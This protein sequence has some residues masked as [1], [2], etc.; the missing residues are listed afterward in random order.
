M[1]KLCSHFVA[2]HGHIDSDDVKHEVCAMCKT[3]RIH[4]TQHRHRQRH[5]RCHC[6]CHCHFTQLQH[7]LYMFY[8]SCSLDQLASRP[9]KAHRLTKM[10]RSID[11]YEKL[12]TLLSQNWNKLLLIR[13]LVAFSSFQNPK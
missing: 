8:G 9:K 10:R 1:C 3:Q 4:K 2:W 13:K 6:H 12:F 7:I 11:E 5:C